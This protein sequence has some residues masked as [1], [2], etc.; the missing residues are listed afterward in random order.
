MFLDFIP[1]W[2]WAIVLVAGVIGLVFKN[3]FSTMLGQVGKPLGLKVQT[4]LIALS[5]IAILMGGW[6]AVTSYTSGIE[7]GTA[8]VVA[9]LTFGEMNVKLT[10]GMSNSTSTEDVIDASNVFMTIYSADASLVESDEYSFNITIGRTNIAEDGSAKVSCV[11]LDGDVTA[12]ESSLALKS[13]GKTTLDYQGARDTGT[14]EADKLTVWTYVDF[15]EGDGSQEIEVKFDQDESY[16]DAM[17]DLTDYVDTTCTITSDA[18][19][20]TTVTRIYAD[21]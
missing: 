3:K 20:K 1:L 14:I 7:L 4:T 18:G 15:A 2:I 17:T 21:S 5:V 6:G 8:T 9:D 13:A 11:L 19:T 10:D 12:S 16:H